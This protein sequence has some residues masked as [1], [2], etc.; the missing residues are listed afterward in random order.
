MGHLYLEPVPVPNKDL[1]NENVG[2]GKQG[3]AIENIKG[4][5]EDSPGVGLLMNPLDKWVF[6]F[7]PYVR[8]LLNP[9]KKR[10]KGLMSIKVGLCENFIW[11]CTGK[12]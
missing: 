12:E 1:K 10:I 9:L 11:G 4:L 8:H 5:F 6:W 2:G 7:N 3:T